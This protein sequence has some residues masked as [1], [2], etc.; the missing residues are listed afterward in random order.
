MKTTHDVEDI[1]SLC[2]FA[3]SS[4]EAFEDSWNS[5]PKRVHLL[6]PARELVESKVEGTPEGDDSALELPLGYSLRRLKAPAYYGNSSVRCLVGQASLDGKRIPDGL[7]FKYLDGYTIPLVYVEYS[8][9]FGVC[10]GTL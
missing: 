8:R 2:Q 7:R 10:G 3:H 5:G 1:A 6:V 4:T 9:A